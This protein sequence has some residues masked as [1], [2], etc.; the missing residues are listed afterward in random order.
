VQ[1]VDSQEARTQ[2]LESRPGLVVEGAIENVL[3][4][5]GNTSQVYIGSL[6]TIRCIAQISLGVVFDIS[7]YMYNFRFGSG[8]ILA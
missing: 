5:G 4:A 7:F 1:I 8:G 3:L 2:L 6:H